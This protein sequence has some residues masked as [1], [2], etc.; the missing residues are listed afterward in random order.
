[1]SSKN[2]NAPSIAFRFTFLY[3]VSVLCILTVVCAGLYWG[4]VSRFDERNRLFMASQVAVLQLLLQNSDPE[5]L[6]REIRFEHSSLEYV[7]HYV[8]MLDEKGRTLEET[9]G[10]A[11]RLPPAVFPDPSTEAYRKA[12][13]QYRAVNGSYYVLNTVV[14]TTDRKEGRTLQIALDVTEIIRLRNEYRDL[15]SAALIMGLLG[16]VAAGFYTATTS[17]RPLAAMSEAIESVSASTLEDRIRAEGWPREIAVVARSFN[18][19]L[20]RLHDSFDR[21]TH[22]TS[23]MAHELRTPITNL[24]GEAE[25]ALT[26]DRPVEEYRRVIESSLEEYDRLGKMIDALM[27]LTWHENGD[28]PVRLASLDLLHEVQTLTDF[29]GAVAEESG[30]TIEVSGAGVVSADRSLFHRAVGH[31]LSNALAYTSGGTIRVVVAGEPS[32][33]TV[34]V[35]DTGCGIPEKDLSRVFDRFFRV[36]ATRKMAP[37]GFGLGLTT[38][39]AI[40]DLHGGY[41]TIA[42]QPGRGTNVTLF[43]P[44]ISEPGAKE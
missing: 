41:V 13:F 33:A 40:M 42:S 29:Y 7:K 17:L 34:T 28:V 6:I 5:P 12:N 11:Q 21:L 20:E 30:N 43:F 32:G 14:G 38:V 36:D 26:R 23:N 19:M 16:T 24:R 31:I 2:G 8:R 44:A 35:S 18:R 3:S 9:P 37:K 25:V 27:F 10:M 15:L 39:R 22:C 4:L 1:M